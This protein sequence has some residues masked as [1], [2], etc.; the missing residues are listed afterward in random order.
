MS[1]IRTVTIRGVEGRRISF[2]D[3]PRR[4]LAVDGDGE[5]VTWST[6]WHRAVEAGDAELVDEASAKKTPPALL[7]PPSPPPPPPAASA[8][9]KDA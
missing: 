2:P 4:I 7:S 8:N 3:Q 9:A 6:Y 5:A 1:E